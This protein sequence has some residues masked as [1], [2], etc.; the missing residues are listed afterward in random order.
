MTKWCV[1]NVCI[2]HTT[3]DTLEAWTSVLLKSI[4]QLL[5]Y[6]AG[7]VWETDRPKDWQ[8]RTPFLE[9]WYLTNETDSKTDLTWVFCVCCSKAGSR[10]WTQRM[11]NKKKGSLSSHEDHSTNHCHPFLHRPAHASC[12][13]W[14]EWSLGAG[15]TVQA[16]GPHTGNTDS[17]NG[18]LWLLL[19]TMLTETELVFCS[20]VWQSV[21]PP[22]SDS[23]SLCSQWRAVLSHFCFFFSLC[24][25]GLSWLV[26][27]LHPLS[28][29]DQ[30]VLHSWHSS[31]V[32]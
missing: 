27:P 32:C 21:P 30:T 25:F 28:R 12:Q 9:N 7:P 31:C 2:L 11:L 3:V 13:C 17:H 8:D 18:R 19:L 26:C 23:V 10:S 22:N 6:Q 16:L 5:I 29:S 1:T 15:R 4:Q 14:S 20:L 24:F